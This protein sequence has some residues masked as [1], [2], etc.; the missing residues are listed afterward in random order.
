MPY[1]GTAPS[2]ELANADLNGQ[3]L[4]LDVDADT[5][6]H[7]STDDQI[8]FK[9][10]GADDFQMTANTFTVLSGS[11][12]AVASGATIA[13]SG[14]ATGFGGSDPDS[15]DGDSLGTASAEWSDLY[16]ADGGVIYFGND[17][18]ITLTH[19]ADSGLLLKH[20][21]T[22]DDKPINLTLQ[23]GET[24]IASNDVLGK[25]SFQAPDEGTGTDAILV[26]GAIQVVSEGDFSSSNNAVAMEFHTAASEAAAV[27]AKLTSTGCF[28]VS[29]GTYSLPGLS[30]K[31][32][33]DCGL[34]RVGTNSVGLTVAGSDDVF[35]IDSTKRVLIGNVASASGAAGSINA[36]NESAGS[37]GSLFENS[38]NG[39]HNFT[40]KM[41][42]ADG[43]GGSCFQALMTGETQTGIY[44]HNS[45]AAYDY[46]FI[47]P[48]TSATA[49]ST[50]FN[51]FKAQATTDVEFYL[52]GDGNATCDGSWSGGGADYAEY[53][54]WA[55]G[56]SAKED[57]VGISVVLAGNLIRAA[58]G[59]DAAATII[60]VVSGNPVVIGDTAW[61]K[62]HG[63]HLRDDFGRYIWEEISV[64]TWK[65]TLSE[66][67]PDDFSLSGIKDHSYAFDKIPEGVT[68]PDNV[69][70]VMVQ[71][72]KVNPEW[73]EMVELGEDGAPI[74][75]LNGATISKYV[76]REDR[77]EWDAIG[78]MGKLRIKKGQPV[79]DRWIKM[80]DIS[81]S[82][83]E[84]LIR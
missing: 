17:Q 14:T 39:N 41:T 6:L 73:V 46:H 82:V 80:R 77:P 20:T 66:S 34:Y 2:S 35:I 72:R 57:R 12:L 18:E 53:F 44:L 50:A 32:D 45:N 84:W 38:G 27:K 4:I 8:D 42:H 63:K 16:L 68:V 58:T 10:S 30:F 15:A 36:M 60:G 54:E 52:K 59:D 23:T 43:A 79:G 56:N 71:R 31:D 26:A 5:S 83:E 37:N 25:I 49:S 24:D 21:A 7:A 64:Y 13:N 19:S 62:W 3:E 70:P 76:P 9:I 1:I 22:A 78:L 55:D 81:D 69:E 33:T 40:S 61:N 75:D 11:T 28:Q 65:E 67:N 48:Y 47:N 51:F 29:N 74:K